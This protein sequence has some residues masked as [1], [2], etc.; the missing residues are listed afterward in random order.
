MSGATWRGTCLGKLP[1]GF[2]RR[3]AQDKTGNPILNPDGTPK[4]VPCHDPSTRE[5]VWLMYEMYCVKLW[6]CF[7]IAKRFNELKVDSSEGW[8]P[9]SIGNLLGNPA[10]I[11]VF[12]WNR[13]HSEF[14]QEEECWVKVRNP[15]S[16][17]EVYFDPKLAIISLEWWGIA[18]HRLAAARRKSPRTGK[19]PSRN[20]KPATTLFSGTLFCTCGGE[21]LLAR[22]TGKY[23]SMFCPRA[24]IGVHGCKLTT[25][26]STRI[27]ESCL[28]MLPFGCLN[29]SQ[30]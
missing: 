21:L 19:K 8:T 12:I 2:A 28:L 1:L 25:T 24:K 23:K 9:G 6:S 3:V 15:R 30:I 18:K 27:I 29:H 17:W 16:D 4:H 20:Q 22:S 5:A 13:T 10:S 7:R 14:D 26:K 11:G